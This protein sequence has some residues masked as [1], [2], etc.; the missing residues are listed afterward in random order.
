[1]TTPMAE[2]PAD[3]PRGTG[4][5][6][7]DPALA[8]GDVGR[9]LDDQRRRWTAGDRVP[10]EAYLP[11]FTDGAGDPVGF[12]DLVYQE[13]LLREQLGE[14]PE[15]DEYLRRF[16]QFARA[17]RD[18]FEVHAAFPIPEYAGEVGTIRSGGDGGTGARPASGHLPA[19]PG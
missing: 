3:T 6:R 2:N 7:I 17:I 9:L 16:P 1:M 18:Q 12:L 11:A 10:A 13:V 14:T 15:P 8:G 5:T 19:V 4:P